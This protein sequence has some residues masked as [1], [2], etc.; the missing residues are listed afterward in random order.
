MSEHSNREAFNRAQARHDA[1]VHPDYWREEPPET[2]SSLSQPNPINKTR[3]RAIT[4]PGTGRSRMTR[5]VYGLLAD[6]GDG[7][8]LRETGEW[9]DTWPEMR[10]LL[11]D[12][13]KYGPAKRY[14][15]RKRR[16]KI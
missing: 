8:G 2:D 5:D 16:L 14:S 6:F 13:R 9:R 4:G 7:L 12:C 1:Q 10:E 15:Y 3:S 11:E